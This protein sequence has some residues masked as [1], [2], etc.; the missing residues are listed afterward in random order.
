MTPNP[1]VAT[2]VTC[3]IEALYRDGIGRQFQTTKSHWLF[4]FTEYVQLES[5]MRRSQ[6]LRFCTKYCAALPALALHHDGSDRA[7]HPPLK[8]A[9]ASML[10]CNARRF[11]GSILIESPR[12]KEGAD[13]KTR[14]WRLVAKRGRRRETRRRGLL[15]STDRQ[16]DELR[17]F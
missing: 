7:S 3:A 8:N 12:S 4:R 6:Q 15:S 13:L 5:M 2:P 10:A 1:G 14:P 9:Q 17:C 16:G 11:G